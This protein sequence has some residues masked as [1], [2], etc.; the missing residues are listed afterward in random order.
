[1]EFS[2][3]NYDIDSSPFI[4]SSYSIGSSPVVE[5][6]G[7]GRPKGS[8]NKPK[9][10]E[11]LQTKKRSF[12]HSELPRKKMREEQ[13]YNRKTM[14]VVERMTMEEM[15]DLLGRM[16]TE[17]LRR[18]LPLTS[19]EITELKANIENPDNSGDLAIKIMG[20]I[21]SD[22]GDCDGKEVILENISIK[23]LR[24]LEDLFR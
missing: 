9:T 6:R 18:E 13:T 1:M 17:I 20:M 10:F 22:L 19:T 14:K 8:K 4:G 11:Q 16:K 23:T 2:A 3:F 24:D 5:K 12:H 21:E 15:E 7:R